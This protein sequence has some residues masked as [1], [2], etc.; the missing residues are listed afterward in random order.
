M[1]MTQDLRTYYYTD[2][3]VVKAVD[4][5]SLKIGGDRKEV[6][7]LVGESG[8]GKSTLALSILKLL[9]PS[10]RIVGGKILWRNSD[11]SRYTEKEMRAIRGREISLIFQNP[12]T[13]LNPLMKVGEQVM[14]V[15]RVHQSITKDEAKARAFEALELVK[16]P[17][18]E[19]FNRYPHELSGGMRQRVLIAMAVS[20]NPSLIIAD[21][22]TTNLDVTVQAQILDLFKELK[23]KVETSF[24]LITHNLGLVAEFC[25]RVYI[26]YAGKVVEYGDIYTIFEDPKHPYTQAL[27]RCVLSIEYFKERIIGI[28]GSV[29]DL[30]NPPPGCVYHP[31]CPHRR[32]ICSNQTPLVTEIE[33]GHGVSCWLYVD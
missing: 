2:R 9:P 32:S 19:V 26:M 17:S 6:V 7:G 21:E 4:K 25:D 22:P 18:S 15:I 20:T 30:I 28:E 14:E 29:P 10:A 1:L 33:K 24:L 27:L 12:E 13:Y 8:C 31:R 3:G 23:E 11:L 5:V 16:L